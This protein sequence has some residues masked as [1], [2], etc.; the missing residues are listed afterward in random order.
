EPFGLRQRGGARMNTISDSAADQGG[1]TRRPGG[2]GDTVAVV[3]AGLIGRAWAIV[4]ARSGFRV[5]LHDQ[6]PAALD[7]CLA[8]IGERLADLAHYALI[9]ESPDTVL[10]RISI[11]DSLAGAVG[12]AVLVQENVA[13]KLE[14]KRELFAQL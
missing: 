4:F 10:A 6:L 14:V 9:E 1:G 12:Q 3:G 7:N 8:T 13:E 11:A 5:R 2:G